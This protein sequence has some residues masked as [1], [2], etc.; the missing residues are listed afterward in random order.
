MK[1][2]DSDSIEQEVARF[3]PLRES[4]IEPFTDSV[5][6][7]DVESGACGMASCI[8]VDW[9]GTT[10]ALSCRHFLREGSEYYTGAKLVGSGPMKEGDFNE[11]AP[12]ELLHSDADFDL[13]LFGLNGLA[14]ASIPKQAYP[15]KAKPL[16]LEEAQQS[17]RCVSFIHAVPG[18]AAKG[19]QYPQ[20][21]LVFMQRPIYSAYG[22]IL[23]VTESLIVGDF[24][25]KK[26][27]ERNEKDFP[28]LK[29][30]EPTGGTRDLSGMSGSGL[31]VVCEDGFRLLG[32]LLGAA[33][34]NQPDIEH[35][36]R[37]TP[38]WKVIDWLD[39]LNL[40]FGNDDA[41]PSSNPRPSP[42]EPS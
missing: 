34:D 32:I 1:E 26:L 8:Y 19:T 15:L 14:L 40:T 22:P 27:L 13:S 21:G 9:E 31:W 36:I 4:Q 42:A 33:K 17:L 24:A 28:H 29:D 38:I 20:D 7:R 18:F 35:R 12:L 3:L 41:P 10:Y 25:E 16:T 11:I 6:R 2:V 5:L 37:F 23:E 39:S 30:V